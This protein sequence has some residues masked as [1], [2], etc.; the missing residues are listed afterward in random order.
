MKILA[1]IKNKFGVVSK[2]VV[3]GLSSMG[4]VVASTGVTIEASDLTTITDANSA[5]LS[6]AF[7]VVELLPY[8]AVLAGWFYVLNKLFWIIP[9]AGWNQ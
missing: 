2:A 6:S 5:Y 8:I 7:Q 3:T 9:K 4:I 1:I